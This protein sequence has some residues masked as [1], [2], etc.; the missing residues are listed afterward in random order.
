MGYSSGF[1]LRKVSRLLAFGL[2]SVF[3]IVQT[4]SYNGYI[5]VN[6]GG[7]QK[8]IEVYHLI[9]MVCLLLD[10]IATHYHRGIVYPAPVPF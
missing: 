6:Y 1:C 3:I 7:I 10:D 2:G 5:N 4:M 9:I 8:D